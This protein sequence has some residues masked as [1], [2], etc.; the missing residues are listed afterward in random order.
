MLE[1]SSAVRTQPMPNTLSPPRI[2]RIGHRRVPFIM[3]TTVQCV[4]IICMISIHVY[5]KMT[6]CM[7]ELN[8]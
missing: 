6:A 4:P 3:D 8:M 1:L 5:V 7:I 2:M